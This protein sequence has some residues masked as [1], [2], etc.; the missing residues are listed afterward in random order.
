V[1]VKEERKM[2]L[3]L[4][5]AVV[6]F[7]G[8][9]SWF[10][11]AFSPQLSLRRVV[12]PSQTA[13]HRRIKSWA[14]QYAT[15]P[16]EAEQEAGAVNTPKPFLRST[17]E[18]IWGK[19]IPYEKL[20]IGVI[21]ETFPGENRVSQTPDS[22][23]SL[24]K[25]GF[26]V[27]VQAGGT[28]LLADVL[29]VLRISDFTTNSPS[30]CASYLAFHLIDCASNTC[31]AGEKASFSD[32]AFVEAGA[33]VLHGEQIFTAAD[34]F[35]KIRPPTDEEVLN[36]AGKTLFSTIQ[37]AINGELFQQ[38][39]AQKTNTFA[40]DCVPRLLSRGQ[41]FD[42][43]SSQAN[44]A[45]YRA[46]IE[47]AQEFPRFFA[48]QMTAAGKVAPAKVLVLGTGVAGLAAIQTAKNMGAIVRGFDVR[49]V[50]KE[51]VESM[52]ATFLE[53]PFEEDGSGSGGYAKEMVRCVIRYSCSSCREGDR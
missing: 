8:S 4:S 9:R 5:L 7:V 10:A 31:T 52:G 51:Q 17:E 2:K 25:E 33:I 22:I 41:S 39:V 21:K 46:V 37:P 18:Q 19:P 24:V 1:E 11:N 15:K 14:P 6:L 34:I 40:L 16:K 23:R 44:I 29:F 13:S 42:T 12:V 38:L 47:A 20:T 35:T 50:T 43:L 48:G 26:N 30:Y 49:P 53:V 32:A 36:L 3:S 27:V 45:G 28:Y